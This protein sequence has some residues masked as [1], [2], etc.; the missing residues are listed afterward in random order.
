M[1]LLVRGQDPAG[2]PIFAYVAVRADRLEVFMEAQKS[3][4]FYPEEFGVIIEAGSGL[5]SAEVR[6][7][8]K[9]DY[10]FEE[11]AMIDVSD[12]EKAHQLV[13]NL[14][15]PYDD[16]P[17]AEGSRLVPAVDTVGARWD[18]AAGIA[19]LFGS[20]TSLGGVGQVDVG[21]HYREKSDGED[22]TRLPDSWKDLS[23]GRHS[24]PG[25]FE[26]ELLWLTSG[27]T[28]EYRACVMH[29][30]API[31]GEVRWFVATP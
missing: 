10:G 23:S 7:K 3:G 18:S 21:F 24:A 9:E 1:I 26:S 30:L 4:M 6:R 8:M 2:F 28:Y 5:P 20:I 17:A 12:V 15:S 19:T 11:D 13:V 29:P 14:R 31:L 16:G 22:L 25:D 27:T